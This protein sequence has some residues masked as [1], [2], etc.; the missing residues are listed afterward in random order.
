MRWIAW[1][2]GR[3]EGLDA[4]VRCALGR[5]GVIAAADKRE[6]DGASPL[7]AWPVRAAFFRPD[8]GE[9]PVTALPL[10]PIAETDGWSDDPADPAYNTHVRLPHPF[11]HERL[12][13]E[14]GL[15]D[16]VV[17]L[18]YNDDPPVAGRGS[19]IFLHCARED[20]AGTEGCVALA[21]ADLDRVLAR[22]AP[23]DVVEIHRAAERLEPAAPV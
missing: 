9:C 22:L 23:G 2:D 6:G 3:F 1:S 18:G 15:Y 10:A 14:D 4:P 16:R 12:Q 5:A 17:T 13:R 19:A 11:R 21:R 8:R 7:G 20:Y